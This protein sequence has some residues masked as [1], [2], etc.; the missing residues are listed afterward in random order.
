MKAR[1]F[2]YLVVTIGLLITSLDIENIG[3]SA[4]TAPAVERQ[5][6]EVTIEGT[7]GNLPFSREG[8]LF[9][10]NA[11]SG[12]TAEGQNRVNL[13]L[14]SGDPRRRGEHG[15]I[16]LAT[17][18]RFYV[19]GSQI[20]LAPTIARNFAIDA[21]FSEEV[22][23]NANAFSFNGLSF[24]SLTKISYGDIHVEL[25]PG[26]E[27]SGLVALT[28]VNPETGQVVTYVADFYGHYQSTQ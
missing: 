28:G 10:T 5:V 2:I 15:A 3:E 12:E 13:W 7:V 11:K 19:N 8:S 18:N 6:Y 21:H 26:G 16:M 17:C 24:E 20:D 22:E 23:Q 14:V 9:L 4:P 27:I 1:V 25:L